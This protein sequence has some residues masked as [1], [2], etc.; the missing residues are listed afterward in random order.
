MIIQNCATYSSVDVAKYA[1]MRLAQYQNI[2]AVTQQIMRLHA[3]PERHRANAR[4]QAAQIRQCLM[5]AREYFEA[6]QVVSL[7]TRPVLLYYS[8]MSLALC[9]ILLKQSADSRLERLR[10]EHGCH[11]LS[12]SLM[13]QTSPSDT[14]ADAAAAL[15]AKPQLVPSGLARGTFEVWRRSSRELPMSGMLTQALPGTTATTSGTAVLG[16]GLDIEPARFPAGGRSLLSIL[17]CLPQ[18]VELVYEHDVLPNLV[19]AK[20]TA[21]SDATH[22]A[23]VTQI[24][25]HPGPQILIDAFGNQVVVPASDSPQIDIQELPS[26]VIFSFPQ[27]TAI[28]LPWCVCIDTK[29][30]WMSTQQENLNEFGLLYVGLHIAGNFA[31]YYPDKWLA[32]IESSSP[33]ALAIDRLTETAFD[34]AP[35]LALCEFARTQLLRAV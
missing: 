27:K 7:A 16:V 24:T 14:L 30:V 17:Q 12:L 34:R 18:M 33:L 25:V 26:G 11:G 13:S 20:C 2:E 4:R 22:L 32:H 19:R 15:I 9:E 3:L 10:A 21:T 6:A 23:R 1:W 28:T 31:R 35:L 8:L 29:S 5:Q